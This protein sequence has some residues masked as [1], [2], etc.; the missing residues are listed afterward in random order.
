MSFRLEKC[1]KMVIKKIMVVRTEW[2]SLPEGDI[3]DTELQVPGKNLGISEINENH[4][5][6]AKKA[7]TTTKYLQRVG[8]S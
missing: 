5:E 6:A 7:T 3:A 8:V 1:N 4:E 2:I